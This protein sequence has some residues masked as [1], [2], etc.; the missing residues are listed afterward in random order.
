MVLAGHSYGGMVITGVADRIAAPDRGSGLSRC[1]HPGGRQSLFDINI[2]KNVQMYFEQAPARL[3][4]CAIPAPPAAEFFGVNE[5]DAARV[6]ELAAPHPIG[7]FTEK[8]KL[9]GD[10]QV[11]EK[12]DLC[13]RRGIA[14]RK[15]V[16]AVL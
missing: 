10:Y 9:T 3:A 2:P 4:A 15:P 6:D 12:A 8:I 1:V 5:Q 16:Q 13:A 14:A 11:G 7:C